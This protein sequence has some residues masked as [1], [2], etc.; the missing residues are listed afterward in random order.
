MD[1]LH[2]FSRQLNAH[3]YRT[4]KKGQDNQLSNQLI[5]NTVSTLCPR[6]R[7]LTGPLLLAEFSSKSAR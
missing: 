1:R 3:S 7:V 5:K 4:V 2:A 6:L